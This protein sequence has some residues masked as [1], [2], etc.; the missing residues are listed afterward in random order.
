MGITMETKTMMTKT[1]WY[2]IPYA[3]RLRIAKLNEPDFDTGVKHLYARQI[4]RTH[5]H[6]KTYK[7]LIK[8]WF[9]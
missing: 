9:E 5:Y 3:D 8:V 6:Y 2:S 7:P 4:D 1:E